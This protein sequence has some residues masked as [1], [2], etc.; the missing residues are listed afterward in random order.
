MR[1]E[2]D[3]EDFILRRYGM[4][5]SSAGYFRS[6]GVSYMTSN[7][8][9]SDWSSSP[10][11]FGSHYRNFGFKKCSYCKRIGEKQVGNCE[12]CGAPL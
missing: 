8:S 5:F 9:T 7:Y 3:E 10:Q 12:G 11:S 2:W 4:P 6:T 1:N